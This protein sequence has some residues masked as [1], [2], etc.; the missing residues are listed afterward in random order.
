VLNL[1]STV[2]TS[3]L[4]LLEHISPKKMAE[5]K[6]PSFPVRRDSN[7]A[8]DDPNAQPLMYQIPFWSAEPIGDYHYSLEVISEGSVQQVIP[9]GNK[10]YH[11]IGRAPICDIAIN[12]DVRYPFDTML[13]PL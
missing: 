3:N 6:A 2:L 10:A 9:L 13:C 11:L 1:I 7:S 5:F 12:S 8:S 4:S